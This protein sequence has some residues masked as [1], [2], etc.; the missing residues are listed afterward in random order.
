[1]VLLAR[2]AGLRLLGLFLLFVPAFLFFSVAPG[3]D[4]PNVAGY[5]GG[6]WDLQTLW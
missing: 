5:G 3:T 4:F 6:E 1:M 2:A